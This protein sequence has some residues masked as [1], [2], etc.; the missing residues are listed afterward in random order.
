MALL[1]E[2]IGVASKIINIG[3]W[4]RDAGCFERQEAGKQVTNISL[5]VQAIW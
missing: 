4:S 3:G 1:R 5:Y 2:K